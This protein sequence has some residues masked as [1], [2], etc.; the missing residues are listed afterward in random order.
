[1][2]CR[3]R[4]GGARTAG[5]FLFDGEYNDALIFGDPSGVAYLD[6]SESV[7]AAP[8]LLNALTAAARAAMRRASRPWTSTDAAAIAATNDTGSFDSMGASTNCRRS[9]RSSHVIDPSDEQSATAVLDKI[10]GAVLVGARQRQA[11]FSY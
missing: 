6:V 9:T 11:R 5:R 10:S 4:L 7:A 1:M 8:E 2:P 3:I